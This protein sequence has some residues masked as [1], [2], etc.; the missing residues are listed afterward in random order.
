[1]KTITFYSYKGG[2]GRSLA[3]A[4]AAR[5]LARLNF[6]VIALDFDL[7]A[8]GLH[9][10]FTNKDQGKAPAVQAGI[11]D[12]LHNYIMEGAIPSFLEKFVIKIDVPGT[13]EPVLQLI[14]AGRGPSPEYWE[15][16]SRINW[17]E[18]FYSS[19]AKGVHLFLDLKQRIL[20]ELKPDFLLIDSRTGITEMGGVATTLLADLVI[21]LV[22][23]TPENMEG[24]RAVLRNLKRTR[25]EM[26]EENIELMLVLSRLP[27]MKNADEESSIKERVRSFFNEESEVLEDTLACQKIFTLHSEEA[28]ELRE[29]LRVG[30][31]LSIDDSILLRDY[32]LLFSLLVPQDLMLAKLD[33]VVKRA[34]IQIWEDRKIVLR[35]MEEFA[36][37]FDH[38]EIYRVLFQLYDDKN[39][40]GIAYLEKAQRY[41]QLSNDSKH[42]WVVSVIKNSFKPTSR[43]KKEWSPDLDFISAVWRD[44]GTY[45]ED[46]GLDLAKF[47]Q[48]KNQYSNAADVYLEILGHSTERHAHIVVFCLKALQRANRVSEAEGIINK[49]RVQFCNNHGFVKGWGEYALAVKHESFLKELTTPQFFAIFENSESLLPIELLDA[50]GRRDEAD[51]WAKTFLLN[52]NNGHLNYNLMKIGVDFERLGRWDIFEE[53]VRSSISDKEW[54]E[55]RERSNRDKEF[56]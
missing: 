34:K 22:L 29:T 53:C 48:N 52:E 42:P 37:T 36:K 47:Y 45:D 17:H 21:C 41:W 5:F 46:L 7:E 23:P 20:D 24:A 51:A 9:Y 6:K 26:G 39:V 18:L 30:G 14:P 35:E 10:K 11:V 38:P 4:N 8:P 40:L 15:K 19:D 16:L 2:T 27:E 50:I 32:F 31:T 28:L 33:F 25:R 3:V 43:W 12:Y 1:M 13:E 56:F 49:Y 55:F 54:K 44:T